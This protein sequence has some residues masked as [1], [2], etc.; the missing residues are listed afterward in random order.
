M[1]GEAKRRRQRAAAAAAEPAGPV[2]RLWAVMETDPTDGRDGIVLVAAPNGC[3]APMLAT[4]QDDA[5]TLAV[6]AEQLAQERGRELRL[7]EFAGI[8]V[9]GRFSPLQL[10]RAVP[11]PSRILTES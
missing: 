3:P 5:L 6:V 7:M 9:L 11:D 2:L 4:D 1:A 10:S 8:G